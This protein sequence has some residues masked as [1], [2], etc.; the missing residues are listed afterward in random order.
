MKSIK[1]SQDLVTK[2][3]D[4]IKGFK[5]QA[6]EKLK[7]TNQYIDAAKKFEKILN[8]CKSF[9]EIK[10]LIKDN[11]IKPYLIS[12][13]GFSEKSSSHIKEEIDSI[14]AGIL[15]D[16]FLD[17]NIGKL[18]E[19]LIAQFLLIK[20]DSM[21][22][23]IRN[24]TGNQAGQELAK[25]IQKKLDEKKIKYEIVIDKKIQ[26][27]K[28]YFGKIEEYILIKNHRKKYSIKILI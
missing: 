25:L 3:E 12:A 6:E 23:T 10:E 7:I 15:D 14:L 11:N 16:L 21:G 28:K 17:D 26:N 2:K 20:G 18:K 8:E 9:E 13:L 5:K 4:T 19:K 1:S 27:V 22:G 24:L